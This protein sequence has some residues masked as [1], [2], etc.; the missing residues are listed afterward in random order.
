[1]APAAIERGRLTASMVQ[2]AASHNADVKRLAVQFVLE[3][4]NRDEVVL[5][6]NVLRKDL[7]DP[8]PAV[9]EVAV[10][11]FC[12][13]ETLVELHGLEAV[14]KGL[15]DSNPRVRKAAVV[16]VGNMNNVAPDLVAR[17]G[18]VDI[19]YRQIRDFDP[20][21]VTF[22]LQTLNVI[23]DTE[24]G[25]VINDNMAKYLV[26]RL[27]DIPDNEELCFLLEYLEK[28]HRDRGEAVRVTILNALDGLLESKN[29][30]VFLSAI[31]LFHACCHGHELELKW[32]FYGKIRGQI[33]RFLAKSTSNANRD[34]FLC[35]LVDFLRSISDCDAF[36]AN[37][38]DFYFK[39]KDSRKLRAS[40][41]S[42]LAHIAA[43]DEDTASTVLTYL[44]ET[45]I[46]ADSVKAACEI[47]HE[48]PR[49]EEQFADRLSKADVEVLAVSPHVRDLPRTAVEKVADWF[50]RSVSRQDGDE[51]V[52]NALWIL[53]EVDLAEAPLYLEAFCRDSA[54]LQ[55][56]LATTA[57][58][59]AKRPAE[60]QHVL[61]A[62]LKL[63]VESKRPDLIARSEFYA[64]ILRHQNC[65]D[66][67][68][69]EV[70]VEATECDTK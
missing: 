34:E 35:Q 59:F 41:T 49:L 36:R 66:A 27:D 2:L 30:P 62:C 8:N 23:L 7:D 10:A 11:A 5:I 13:A 33:G 68:D 1:M 12:K 69:S 48:Y 21:V 55:P 38:Q 61:A 64:S 24:G 60:L 31:R 50:C 65:V 58:I 51:A 67:L 19:L 25:V 63:C 18:L 70:A 56:L 29:G 47:C 53:R 15:K 4:A 32:D 45:T 14:E 16:G 39:A 57:A 42:M 28:Y 17:H 44:L 26:S 37:L 3:A 46:D 52:I 40:K 43:S 6:A 22:A 9:R 54:P 20:S